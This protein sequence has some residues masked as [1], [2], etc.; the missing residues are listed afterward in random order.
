MGFNNNIKEIEKLNKIDPATISERLCK[1]MEEVGELAQA[2]NKTTGRKFW[3][4]NDT[5]KKI[6]ENILEEGVD[7][8]QCIVSLLTQ[9][10][11]NDDDIISVME[12]KNKAWE[13]SMQKNRKEPII[14][15]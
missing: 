6:N 13:K 15:K 11:F 10:G 9:M 4:K 12:K 7:S 14:R 1:V 5:L 3:K 8:I 2:I